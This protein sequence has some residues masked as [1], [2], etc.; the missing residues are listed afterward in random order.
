VPEA[1]G[2]LGADYASYMMVAAE[3]GRFCGATALTYNM[4][5][6]STL[7]TGVLA[8]GIPMT[9]A[10]RAEHARRRELH[11]GRVVRDGAVYAQPF[12][13]GQLPRRPAAHRS[14]PRRARWKAAGW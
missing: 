1:Y 5:I 7:W 14:A 11:F 3:I 4:H 6:C 13:E 9:E 10:E 8:D 2:G 12:S